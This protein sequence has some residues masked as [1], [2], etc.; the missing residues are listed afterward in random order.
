MC[1]Y[2][3]C[4]YMKQLLMHCNMIHFVCDA[5]FDAIRCIAKEHD[6]FEVSM[7]QIQKRI[8]EGNQIKYKIIGQK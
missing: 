1:I 7:L 5:K 2:I 4:I 3:I 6:A 8:K